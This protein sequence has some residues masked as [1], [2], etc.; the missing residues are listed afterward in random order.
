MLY[1]GILK[2]K[3]EKT[4]VIFEISV[5]KFI[6]IQIY[7]QNKKS[8]KYGTKNALFG[9]FGAVTRI[10]EFVKNVFLANTVNLRI[11]SAFSTDA[12]LGP[13]PGLLYKIELTLENSNTQFLE[14][15][16]SS[17]KLYGPL[18]ITHFFRQKSSRYLESRHLEYLGR[19]NKIVEPLDDFLSFSRTFV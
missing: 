19:S 9:Y 14:L 13:G 3:F 16:D 17:N 11:G 6:K 12:D 4:I 5:L 8:L 2:L 18:N 1:L 10:L 7:M 15:F